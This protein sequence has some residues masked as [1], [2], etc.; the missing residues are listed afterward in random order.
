MN[1]TAAQQTT[2]WGSPEASYTVRVYQISASYGR[3]QYK[4]EVVP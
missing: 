2:D 4:E 1:Y 3:G